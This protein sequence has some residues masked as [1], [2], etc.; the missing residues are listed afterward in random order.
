MANE[1]SVLKSRDAQ[2]RRD[3]LSTSGQGSSASGGSPASPSDLG[4]R[5]WLHLKKQSSAIVKTD[6]ASDEPVQTR[7]E[8]PLCHRPAL[9]VC[10]CVCVAQTMTHMLVLS[11]VEMC[12]DSS[13]QPRRSCTFFLLHSICQQL[14][15]FLFN[16]LLQ[17]ETS[18]STCKTWTGFHQSVFLQLTVMIYCW[19]TW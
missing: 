2:F 16:F 19:W 6:W 9:S 11:G 1:E 17:I 18:P 4:R 13:R 10:V 12:S 8:A 14:N 5:L 7:P 3:T 15:V